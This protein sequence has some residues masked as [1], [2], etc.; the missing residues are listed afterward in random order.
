MAINIDPVYSRLGQI[1]GVD[2]GDVAN[3]KSNGSGTIG[4]DMYLAYTADGVF[5]GW[6]SRIRFSPQSN[7]AATATAATVLRTY[8]STQ[9]S[10]ATTPN[11][12]WLIQEV[13]APAQ[14]ADQ[15]TTAT[16]FIEVPLNF[17]LPPSG[18]ILCS[19]HV[20]NTTH[21]GWTAVVFG[22]KY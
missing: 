20:A 11:D 12:T 16:N 9:N 14:T 6:V 22:G 17:A 2:I 10:G 3:T 7:N 5:G 18:S 13:A 1:Q 8:I 19:S 21:T 4:T 15:T